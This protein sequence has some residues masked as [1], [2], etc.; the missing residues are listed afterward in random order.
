MNDTHQN[1]IQTVDSFSKLITIYY[2]LGNLRFRYTE[3]T[4][5][6]LKKLKFQGV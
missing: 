2:D 3:G 6:V 5:Q 1:G 4:K